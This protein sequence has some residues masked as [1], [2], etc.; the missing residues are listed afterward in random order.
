[1]GEGRHLG[2]VIHSL[3]QQCRTKRAV[4][5]GREPGLWRGRSIMRHGAG[6]NRTTRL[7][8]LSASDPPTEANPSRIRLES[9]DFTFWRRLLADITNASASL[10]VRQSGTEVLQCK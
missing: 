2:R 7:H 5:L 9:C 1:M 8:R 6:F 3:M 10:R 4:C